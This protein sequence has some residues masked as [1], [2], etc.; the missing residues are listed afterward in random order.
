[1]SVIIL[2]TLTNPLPTEAQKLYIHFNGCI[3]L[4]LNE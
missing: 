4:S 3:F 1:M 2:V